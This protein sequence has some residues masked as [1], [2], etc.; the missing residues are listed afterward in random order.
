VFTPPRKVKNPSLKRLQKDRM[1]EFEQHMA[2]VDSLWK[3][4]PSFGGRPQRNAIA[5]AS[6]PAAVQAKS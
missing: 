6:G 1:P 4:T 5:G 2:Q 3:A